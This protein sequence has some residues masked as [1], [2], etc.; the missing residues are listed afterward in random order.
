M[1]C[2]VVVDAELHVIITIII[3]I[4]I[5]LSS[6]FCSLFPVIPPAIMYQ[7]RSTRPRSE[8]IEWSH[9]NGWA[10]GQTGS[11]VDIIGGHTIMWSVL[12]QMT[13]LNIIRHVLSFTNSGSNP[14]HDK[15]LMDCWLLIVTVR[16]CVYYANLVR[17]I[18]QTGSH[19]TNIEI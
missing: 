13:D 15:Y 9:C 3:I 1:C 12:E 17:Q 10:E 11:L 5:A 7:P 4:E 2:A 18:V 19:S 8:Q 14:F 16:F 6:Q